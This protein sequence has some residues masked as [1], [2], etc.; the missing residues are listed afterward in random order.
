MPVGREEE[1]HSRRGWQW[2]EYDYARQRLLLR[3]VS[4]MFKRSSFT[5]QK[6][7]MSTSTIYSKK[8]KCFNYQMTSAVCQ[9][10]FFTFNSVLNALGIKAKRI[11]INRVDFIEQRRR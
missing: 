3:W 2:M 6:K 8:D 7:C 1:F 11:N 9:L 5:K 4:Q 10:S